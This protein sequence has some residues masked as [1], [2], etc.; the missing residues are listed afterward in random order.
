VPAP[1]EQLPELVQLPRPPEL[2]QLPEPERLP[3]AEKV[4]ELMQ[5]AEPEMLAEREMLAEPEQL[6]EPVQPPAPVQSAA[7][8]ASQSETAR[9]PEPS[10]QPLQ[11]PPASQPWVT[12]LS[13]PERAISQPEVKRARP[14]LRRS[15][16]SEPGE[17]PAAVSPEPRPGVVPRPAWAVPP[18]ERSQD[19]PAIE[20]SHSPAPDPREAGEPDPASF[21]PPSWPQAG[22]G[23][24]PQA[25][26]FPPAGPFPE[27][28]AFPDPDAFP[29]P[30]VTPER[31]ASAEAGPD[32]DPGEMPGLEL[33]PG[34]DPVPAAKRKPRTQARPGPESRPTSAA[35]AGRSMAAR[36]ASLFVDLDADRPA[37]SVERALNPPAR[38]DDP[39]WRRRVK[40]VAGNQGPSKRDR[41]AIDRDRARLPLP[42]PRRIAVLGCTTGA[43]QS[44]IALMTGHTLA[45]LRDV[46][47]A[48]LDL[49][50][51]DASLAARIE[52]AMSV[53][54]LLA[55]PGPDSP[56][57]PGRGAAQARDSARARPGRSGGRGRVDVIADPP[58]TGG[59][60]PL[61]AEDYQ[62]LARVL[63]ERY[64]LTMIDPAPAG[65]T[66]VLSLANQLVL[67][68]PASPVAASALANTQQ[69]LSAHGFDELAGQAV[70]V[71]NGVTSRSMADVVQAES[72][73]RGRCRA[74]VRVPWDDLLA[75]TA[76]LPAALHPQTRLACTALAGVLVSGL[77]AKAAEPGNPATG[78]PTQVRGTEAW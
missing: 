53:A 61:G 56:V 7:P 39:S 44:M 74:I 57:R 42:G 14:A 73:A 15:R 11:S 22:A 17:R 62:R 37:P 6:P 9:S 46:P 38:P 5:L 72:V 52:P 3:P 23:S 71:V 36:V 8:Q 27:A 49:N 19:A 13:V 77:A 16:R 34:A 45:A 66:R 10:A 18:S 2:V 65:L 50:P 12:P 54:A 20:V 43:G 21:A 24:F 25:A 67:V 59:G 63:A 29:G 69:W 51:G 55:G 41:A 58:G 75:E 28:G 70:T 30:E 60:R 4:A 47:V 76:N 78:S 26:P 64:P 31:E 40:V 32:P 33:P 48:A 35:P 1:P 68:T